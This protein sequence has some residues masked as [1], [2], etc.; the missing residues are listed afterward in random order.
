MSPAEPGSLNKGRPHAHGSLCA[1]KPYRGCDPNDVLRPLRPILL[2]LRFFSDVSS[3]RFGRSGRH[4]AVALLDLVGDVGVLVKEVLSDFAA[5]A[6]A[7]AVI[8]SRADFPRPA[9][10]TPSHQLAHR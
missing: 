3:T 5:L 10:L 2:P 8:V 4:G 1:E 7:A 6:D 9:A